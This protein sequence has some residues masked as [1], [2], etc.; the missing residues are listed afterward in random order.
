MAPTAISTART[1]YRRAEFTEARGL[2]G[3]GRILGCVEPDIRRPG[4]GAGEVD[5]LTD[6]GQRNLVHLRVGGSVAEVAVLAASAG[7]TVSGTFTGHGAVT[8]THYSDRTEIGLPVGRREGR[9]SSC[10]GTHERRDE[11]DE[12]QA[13]GEAADAGHPGRV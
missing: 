5:P 6:P 1:R 11:H 10:I 12:Q 8:Q 9:G 13:S 7:Q 3:L 2:R 4:T